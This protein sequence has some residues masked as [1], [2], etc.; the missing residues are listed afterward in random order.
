MLAPDIPWYLIPPVGLM[1]L[2]LYFVIAIMIRNAVISWKGED[3]WLTKV[4]IYLVGGRFM[5]QDVVANYVCFA[6]MAWSWPNSYNE[7]RTISSHIN[8]IIEHNIPYIKSGSVRGFNR[9]RVWLCLFI[10]KHLNKVDKW[11]IKALKEL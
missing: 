8:A 7:G 4:V 6:P 3:H 1:V 9:Y 11:H 10:A 2:F 5:Y